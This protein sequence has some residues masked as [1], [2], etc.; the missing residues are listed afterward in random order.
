VSRRV[1]FWV[2]VAVQ[3]V[4][5]LALIG[6]NELALATGETVTLRTVPV[7]PIDLFRGRYVT[8]R[9]EISSARRPAGAE[10]GDTV[11]VPLHRVGDHWT[12]ERARPTRPRE[13]PFIRGTITS[14]GIT[15]GIETYY[16][17]EDEARRLERRA[18]TLA[19]R[20]VLDDDG[21]AR[22]SGIEGVR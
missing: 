12:G 8:L 13:R 1:A 22:I 3:A 15:Y 11:Y 10:P 7:D 9:Y 21:H 14:S 6:W 5:P 16:A 19:V 2:L 17:D 18:G 4:V 20:V